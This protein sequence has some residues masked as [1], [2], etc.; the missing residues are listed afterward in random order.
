MD[1][2]ALWLAEAGG[3]GRAP[4]A[5]GTAGALG[6]LGS[7]VLLHLAL[8]Q[9]LTGGG[10][11]FAAV[12]TAALLLLALGSLAAARAERHWGKDSQRI[13]L[14]EWLGM[15][16]ALIGIPFTFWT[17]VLGFVLFRF[18]DIRKPWLARRAEMAGPGLGVMLD[19][20]VAGLYAQILL[21]A[22]LWSGW[23]PGL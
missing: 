17:Y 13:V 4:R 1:R 12:G 8:P 16:V 19:D 10:R 5:P 9:Y 3:L 7:L 15:W 2:A 6:G 22:A 21:R 23:L 18:F 14:D 11:S 20:V